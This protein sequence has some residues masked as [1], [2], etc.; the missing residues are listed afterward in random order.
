MK[1]QGFTLIEVLIVVAI[2]GI[3]ASV[4]L[5]GLGPLQ[6]QGRD[7]RRISDLKQA[8]AGLELYY[9]KCGYYPGT[10]QAAATCGAFSALGSWAAL[11]GSLTGSDI[12]V[13]NFPDDPNASANRSYCYTSA[14]GTEY[15]IGARLDDADN[16]S[17]RQ[18]ID[19]AACVGLGITDCN[20]PVYCVQ[21]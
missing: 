5:V 17:L 10:A 13:S 11:Q 8:Q 16:P 6:R 14:A 15:V 20:D 3:L 7:A 21:L 12:G 4:V 1:K 9:N 19:G 2:I 18:D